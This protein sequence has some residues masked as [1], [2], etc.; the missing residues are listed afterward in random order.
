MKLVLFSRVP[1]WYSFKNER[2]VSHLAAEGFRV[3]GVVV[4]EVPTVKALQEW[5]KKLGFGVFVKKAVQRL[6]GKGNVSG[7]LQKGTG[8]QLSKADIS[9]D[10]YHFKSHNSPECIEKV[11][12][13]APDVIVL[14]GCGIIKPA[15]LDVPKIGVINPH[16]A[17]L[18]EFRGMD[19][20]EWSALHGEP[21]AVSV[22]SVNKGV[23]TGT[24]LKS[25]LIEPTPEDTVGS[26]RDKSAALAVKLLSAALVDLRD[27]KE[28]P[29]NQMNDGGRQFFKMH[30]RLKELANQRLRLFTGK[31]REYAKNN[32]KVRSDLETQN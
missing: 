4:E 25:E 30:P 16:Y 28:F 17:L 15:M 24:V 3:V 18:P 7:D 6:K 8:S 31:A 19:V 32:A 1:R 12:Q 21:I 23:D 26:L 13:L 20:T 29:K 9:P 2:L 10:V 5:T 27:G 14:R 22:H 11:K